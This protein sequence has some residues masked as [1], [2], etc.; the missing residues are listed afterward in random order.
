[1][2]PGLRLDPKQFV[3]VDGVGENG[4]RSGETV[5]GY[6]KQDSQYVWLLDE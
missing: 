5:P 3:S 6:G 1:M 4:S 2:G